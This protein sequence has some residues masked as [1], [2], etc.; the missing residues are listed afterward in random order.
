[1][2]REV[3]PSPEESTAED[4]KIQSEYE[5]LTFPGSRIQYSLLKTSLNNQFSVETFL[6]N[7]EIISTNYITCL[8]SYK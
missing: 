4:S 7:R 1:M 2:M 5:D 8:T 6:G 3:L